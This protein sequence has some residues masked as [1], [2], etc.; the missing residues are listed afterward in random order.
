MYIFS[1]QS[2]LERESDAPTERPEIYRRLHD[3]T[4]PVI[5]GIKSHQMQLQLSPTLATSA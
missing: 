3:D 5:G 1:K 2:N 4:G